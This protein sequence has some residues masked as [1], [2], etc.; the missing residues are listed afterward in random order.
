M[1]VTEL[2]HGYDKAK[3]ASTKSSLL[4]DHNLSEHKVSDIENAFQGDERL[5]Y[6]DDRMYL[7]D[8]V[9]LAVKTGAAK[10]S[11]VA[12]KLIQ[13]GGLYLNGVKWPIGK[14]S[15]DNHDVLLEN[16]LLLLR[17]GKTNYRIVIF[18]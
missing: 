10:S 14:R 18:P 7:N 13:S 3:T 4:F 17:T 16:R 2:V 1:E 12:I 15:I 6:L 5:I 11:T 8:I 9:K